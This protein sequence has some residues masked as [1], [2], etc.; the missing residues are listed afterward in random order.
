[1]E[2]AMDLHPANAGDFA[3][4][5]EWLKQ[6]FVLCSP[7]VAEM[8]QDAQRRGIWRKP[9]WSAK[10]GDLVCFEW[11]PGKHHIGIVKADHGVTLATVEG[12][13]S[14]GARGSQRD[15]D[16]VYERTPTRTFVWGFIDLG[17]S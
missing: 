2:S 12:N 3:W 8:A 9:D 16:G 10:P 6:N 15:G 11:S 5:R 1:M 4:A 14:S 7:S 13:T 17:D